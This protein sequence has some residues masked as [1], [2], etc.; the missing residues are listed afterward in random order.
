MNLQE[1]ISR[2]KEMMR[3]LTED[4]KNRGLFVHP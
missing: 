2:I 1:N 4:V 3:I